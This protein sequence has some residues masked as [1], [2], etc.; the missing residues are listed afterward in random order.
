LSL[1]QLTFGLQ[2]DQ[3]NL[4][5]E[6]SLQACTNVS[7]SSVHVARKAAISKIKDATKVSENKQKTTAESSRQYCGF[8]ESK[9]KEVITFLS[10][11][12]T[13]NKY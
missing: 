12:H 5:Q 7:S 1:S 13:F 11:Q 10:D 4:D 3:E 8:T 9:G 6:I 2:H